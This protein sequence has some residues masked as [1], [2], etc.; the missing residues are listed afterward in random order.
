MDWRTLGGFIYTGQNLTDAHLAKFAS[1]GG[2]WLAPVLYGDDAAGPWNLANVGAL[3]TRA[4]K[5]GLTVGGWFNCAGGDPTK[6]AAAIAKIVTDKGL[7]PVVL[8]LE[9]AYQWPSGHPELMPTLLKALRT[10]LPNAQIAVSTNGLNNAMIWNGRTLSPPQSFY[11]L[12]VRV[13]PQCYSWMW[14]NDGSYRPD[15]L[16]AWLKKYGA[17][18]GNFADPSG[19]YGRGVPLSFVHPTLEVTGMEGSSLTEEL[20]WCRAAKV[21]GLTLGLSIYTLEAI[22]ESDWALLAAERG[23]LF[24]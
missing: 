6:D 19:P 11:D 5:C 1:A 21:Y 15:N 9:A 24:L 2:K 8:D 7:S 18:D 10:K 16:M 12:G 3:K 22:S 20:K 14:A 4:A 23:T 13:L 17:T